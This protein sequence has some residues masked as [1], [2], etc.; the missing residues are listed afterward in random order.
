MAS[1]ANGSMGGFYNDEIEKRRDLRLPPFTKIIKII[2]FDT[3]EE[4]AKNNASSCREILLTQI[5]S[6]KKEDIKI[7]G[8]IPSFPYK[9]KN[10]F[11]YEII[12]KGSSCSKLLN[13]LAIPRNWVIDFDTCVS[14]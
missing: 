1:I 6:G 9:L 12:V 5:S 10:N 7:V 8:P 4:I 13:N 14:T 2:I 3:V 11:R